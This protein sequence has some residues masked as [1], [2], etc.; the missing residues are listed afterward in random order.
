MTQDSQPRII[1]T[2]ASGFLG[3]HLVK[4]FLSLGWMVFATHR[5]HSNLFRLNE[6]KNLPVY[7]NLEFIEIDFNLGCEGL[8]NLSGIV[9]DAIIH[10]AAFGVDYRQ[11]SFEKALNI[12]VAGTTHLVSMAAQSNIKRFVH[13]GSALEYGSSTHDI[14][15]NF[16]LSPQ[17]LYGVTKAAASLAALDSARQHRVS[18]NVVRPFGI[19]G[20][21]EGEHK[22]IPLIINSILKNQHLPLSLGQQVRDYVYINDVVDAIA[23]LITMDDAPSGEIFNL[24]SGRPITLYGIGCHIQSIFHNTNFFEDRLA[25]TSSLDWGSMEYRTDEIMH[26]VSCPSKSFEVLGWKAQTSIVDGLR[27][28]ISSHTDL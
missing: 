27:Q 15:E 8:V 10:C 16:C 21:L 11:Q 6:L 25:N 18:L 26:L 7:K 17:G 4:R 2:G 19:Y 23:R 14:T 1:I 22:F 28:T 24:G 20:P 9:A 12:N 5:K 13:I 3:S